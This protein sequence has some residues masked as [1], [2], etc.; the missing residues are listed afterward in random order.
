[1]ALETRELKLLDDNDNPFYVDATFVRGCDHL[2][3]YCDALLNWVVAHVPTSD[4]V[5][6]QIPSKAEAIELMA[7]IGANCSYEALTSD[8]W[9]EVGE[10]LVEAARSATLLGGPADNPGQS[11]TPWKPSWLMPLRGEY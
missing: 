2:A 5:S 3:V 10:E 6:V 4:L 1:M 11:G 7:H 9:E 8:D